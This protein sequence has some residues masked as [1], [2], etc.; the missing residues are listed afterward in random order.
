[1][2]GHWRSDGIFRYL[3]L[4]VSLLMPTLA[5]LMLQGGQDISLTT[6]A[7]LAT[8]PEEATAVIEDLD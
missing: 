6:A 3:D 8:V 4:Q 5:P 1:M 2:V 7:L